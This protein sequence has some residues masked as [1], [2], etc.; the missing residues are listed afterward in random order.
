MTGPTPAN[1][2]APS[3]KTP[4]TPEKPKTNQEEAPDAPSRQSI[5]ALTP[6]HTLD[7]YLK[8]ESPTPM[9]MAGNKTPNEP[10]LVNILLEAKAKLQQQN[11]KGLNLDIK[12][13]VINIL[14]TA[15]QEALVTQTQQIKNLQ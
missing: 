4:C 6:F 2:F 1:C 13:E 8:C 3:N 9:R 10:H 5:R 12:N 11:T 15:I 14:K 7:D